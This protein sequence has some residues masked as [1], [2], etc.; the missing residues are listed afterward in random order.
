MIDAYARQLL[1]FRWLV[2]LVAAGAVAFAAAGLG[3]LRLSADLEVFFAAD[4]PELQAYDV[5]RN[6]YSRDD[7]LF[8]VLVPD[9]PTVFDAHHLAILHEL[10]EAG[11][12]IPYSTRV[13]S[14]ANF[15]HTEA[16][17]DELQVRPLVEDPAGLTPVQF[18]H[19]QSVATREPLL[20]KR[21]ITPS[22]HM[23]AVNISIQ[24]PA[25]NRRLA[26][27]EA[28]AAV[29]TLRADFEG[30]YPGVEVLIT[31]KVA[32]NNAF[33]EA[34]VYDLTHIVPA[35]LAIALACI[36]FYMVIAS[37]SLVTGLAATLA[38]IMIIFASVIVGMGTAGWLGF[39]V[40]PPLVNAPTVILTLAVADCMHLLVTY[41][42]A[43][44]RG[45][46]QHDAVIHSVRMNFQAVLL[47]SLTTVI[48]FLA[49]NFSESPPFHD[50]GNVSAIGIVA[51]WAL[52]MTVLPVLISLMP[53]SVRKDPPGHRNAM[54]RLAGW[55]L[56]NRRGC[57]WG[58]LGL[59]AI[60]TA[61][62]PRN[63]LYDV[64]AE[65]FDESTQIRADSDRARQFLNG[66]NLLEYSLSSGE[67]GG[68]ADPSYLNNLAAFESWLLEQP[69]VTYVNSLAQTMR[70]LN[71]N[72]H[73]DDPA[74]YRIPESRELAA[75]YLLLYEFSLPFGLDLTNQINLDKSASRLSA[76]L[77]SSSTKEILAL[78]SRAQA[79]LRAHTPES[80]YHPGASSDSMFAHVGQRNV[81]SMLLGSALGLL[82]I[83]CVIAV[84]L[85]SLRFGLVSLLLNALPMLVGFGV[86][87][88]L[89]GRIGMGLSVVSGLTMG[90][91]VDYTVHLLS[92]YLLAQREQQLGTEAA[93]RY[94]FS[95]VGSALVVTTIVLC[96]NFGLLAISVFSLNSELGMLT[97]GIILIALA[98]DLFL[99]PP[100][101]LLLDRA[102]GKASPPRRMAPV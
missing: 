80:F 16:T 40:T 75:Q 83:S 7:N 24:L 28:M 5:I 31:G 95:T 26:I 11:W 68:I 9:G 66:F 14:I 42:Q 6:T 57:F 55:V 20:L 13:D 67:P 61:F 44:R 43:R 51:A 58:V 50:L 98:I 101:L 53:G 30:R 2:L 10:T 92:K 1:R 63:E 71:R 8:L 32:G 25:D 34:S 91:V 35:A 97:A 76:G 38:T 41:F 56:Q 60:A 93:I 74:W 73:G 94:A 99:L 27:P 79:W 77:R 65:Y 15:Q 54:D 82:L 87:G 36:A 62:L 3:K 18:Q 17:G 100:L 89:V 49:L 45:Q 37:G 90:I 59:I 46:N 86:W 12:Q 29:R 70:R 88:L 19:I 84:A 81:V 23:A 64:W 22:G 48:G 69:E 47:T 33:T 4:D 78:Q 85:K 39:N 72:M 21:L 102:T 52:S 96:V